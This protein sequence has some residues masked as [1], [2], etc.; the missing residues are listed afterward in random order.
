V[1]FPAYTILTAF[2]EAKDNFGQTALHFA[3][4]KGLTSTV[5]LLLER[6]A[7]VGDKTNCGKTA[8]DLASAN[9]HIDTVCLLLKKES[10]GNPEQVLAIP[11]LGSF[12][13]RRSF[14][15]SYGGDRRA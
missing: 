10:S 1:C 8:L 9:G 11:I 5:S 15:V 14:S 13:N 12:F 3:A 2:I 6:G 4:V 7:R